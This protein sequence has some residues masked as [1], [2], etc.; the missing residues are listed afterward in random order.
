M[1]IG[2]SCVCLVD[3]IESSSRTVQGFFFQS[4][5]AWRFLAKDLSA[6]VVVRAVVT[7]KQMNRQNVA[8]FMLFFCD[9]ICLR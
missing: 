4:R 1:P 9:V 7:V 5:L 2:I 3:T 6:V 8:N